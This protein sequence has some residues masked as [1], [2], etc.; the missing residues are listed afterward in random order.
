MKGSKLLVLSILPLMLLT[1]PLAPFGWAQQQAPGMAPPQEPA[2]EAAPLPG[3]VYEVGAGIATAVNLPLR[4]ALCVVGGVLGFTALLVTFGSGYRF[5]TGIVEEGC[6]GPWVLTA[7]HM[8]GTAPQ[9]EAP[10][11]K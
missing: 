5:A 7:D 10:G 1:G 3:G 8:K 9:K 6:G 4:T 11:Y 2:K